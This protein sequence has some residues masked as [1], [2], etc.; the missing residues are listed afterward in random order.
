MWNISINKMNV[1]KEI[2]YILIYLFKDIYFSEYFFI[3]V[4]IYLLD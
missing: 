3:Y 2:F 1:K 4:C